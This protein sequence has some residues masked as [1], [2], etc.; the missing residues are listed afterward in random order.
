MGQSLFRPPSVA[1]WDWGEAWMSTAT[2][3]A[4][5]QAA[6]WVTRDPP[7]R[8]PEG[9]ARTRWSAAEH[10]ARARAATGAPWTSAATD[11]ELLGL[12]RRLLH[13]DP[14]PGGVQQWRADL[15]QNALRHLLLAGPDAQLH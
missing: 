14:R 5:F 6:T 4:R 7:V 2:M 8:V 10:V 11:R 13:D 1:G 15:T 12:A 9:G 3:R